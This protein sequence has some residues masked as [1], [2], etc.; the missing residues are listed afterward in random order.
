[1][2]RQ[3]SSPEVSTVR[4]P[5]WR[6][7]F[8]FLAILLVV[9]SVF[10]YPKI[11]FERKLDAAR[12][13][14]EARHLLSAQDKIDSGLRRWPDDLQFH[15]LAAR[16]ARLRG[17]SVEAEKQLKLCQDDD[18]LKG[19]VYLERALIRAARGDLD[20]EREL[21]KLVEE[22]NPEW[23]WIL[24]AIAEGHHKQYRLVEAVNCADQWLQEQPDFPPALR[25]KA[26]CVNLRAG[27]DEAVPLYQRA[28]ERDPEFEEARYQLAQ[29]LLDGRTK[30]IPAALAH[31]EILYR[32][33]PQHLDYQVGYAIALV[34]AGRAE[35]A[36]P[37]VEQIV[38]QQPRLAV[39]LLLRGRVALMLDHP[40]QA[41][42]WLQQALELDASRP[43]A[44]FDLAQCLRRLGQESEA[45][46]LAQRGTEAEKD[47]RR[48]F[49]LTSRLIPE[50]PHNADLY[51][52]AGQI[53]LRF[54]HQDQ[55][56]VWFTRAL[57]ED[58]QHLPTH[59]VLAEYFEKAGNLPLARFH[60]QFV[61]KK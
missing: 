7:Y 34:E 5:P 23:G 3:L 59:R 24:E 32:R 36:Q 37:V 6:Y 61:L 57:Q 15:F 4:K 22:K 16:C 49:E 43:Q 38:A 44:Y 1:V 31:F 60:R 13:E 33:R 18:D 12:K 8:I 26:E 54:Q 42:P 52:E 58:P 27:A 25:L 40:D 50:S 21:Q 30:N 46:K 41:L 47:S 29:L 2:S 51:F 56:L 28:L 20:V 53:Q 10:A 11:R 14:L 45:V 9:A 48:M 55:A 19:E 39:G 35:E 17:N